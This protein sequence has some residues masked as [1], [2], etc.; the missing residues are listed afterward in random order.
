MFSYNNNNK[1]ITGVRARL[2]EG[3]HDALDAVEGDG[4]DPGR[5]A[6]ATAAAAA[7]AAA[8]ASA[9]AA[10][11]AASFTFSYTCAVGVFL[12]RP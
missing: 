2:V 11:A 9:A 8:A 12:F 3:P 5:R 10:A 7:A 4:V 1:I 6:A